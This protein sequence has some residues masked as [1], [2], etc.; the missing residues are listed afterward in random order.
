M[1]HPNETTLR[2]LL[3]EFAA[4]NMEATRQYCQPDMIV[5]LPGSNQLSGDYKSYDDFVTRGLG[6][7]MELTG[8]QFSLEPHEVFG[9]DQHGIGVY[10]VKATRDGKTLEW[11]QVNVYHFRD[12]KIAEA[13]INVHEFEAWNK[14]FS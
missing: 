8:Q 14:F 1:A 10:N 4:G 13:W 6:K 3:K 9:N 12:G 2:S 7:I 11:R 5:H